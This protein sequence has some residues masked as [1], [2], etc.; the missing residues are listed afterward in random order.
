MGPTTISGRAA[1]V[2]FCISISISGLGWS[3][4]INEGIFISVTLSGISGSSNGKFKWTGPGG[5][6][7]SKPTAL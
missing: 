2:N 4:D 6:L 7:S 3:V 1:S 5:I